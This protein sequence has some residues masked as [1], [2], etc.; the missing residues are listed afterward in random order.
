MNTAYEVK[1]K[2]ET[3]EIQHP[4]FADLH[5]AL[6]DRIQDALQGDAARIEWVVGP[7]RVGK[8]MLINKLSR[9]Y[10]EE[11]VASKRH[12]P[13]L[14]VP[15]SPNIS[16]KLLPASVLLG[17]GLPVPPRSITSGVLGDRIRDQ[18]RLAGTRVVIF[19]EASHLV[20]PGARVAPRAAGD[21]FKSLADDLNLTLILFGV[22]RLVKLFESNE[23]LRFRA[24]SRKE[25]RP[26]DMRDKTH[27]QAFASCVNAYA[28]LFKRSGWPF[29]LDFKDL[30]LNCYLL[31]GGI[32]GVVSRFMQ[33]L[34][35][36]LRRKRERAITLEDC[37]SAVRNIE[38]V[39]HP[40][41]SAFYEDEV[42]AV[43]LHAVHAHVLEM[44]GMALPEY[45]KTGRAA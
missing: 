38:G 43:A 26:Y 32:I 40:R 36:Q 6:N 34:A 14:V 16:P 4:L 29:N 24:S 28:D 22:P 39:N 25:F 5:E 12:V 13:V 9:S 33:E 42:S 27:Q 3:L 41:F 45:E 15:I 23:Q 10:P 18:L 30:V 11:R 8:S 35:S 17:L 2:I 1:K 31:S 20:E 37:R 44:N 19:E 7:S 21:W